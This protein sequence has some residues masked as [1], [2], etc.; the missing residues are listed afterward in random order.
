M[1]P[2]ANW[3][4]ISEAQVNPQSAAEADPQS[5]EAQGKD[6]G[7]VSKNSKNKGLLETAKET[8]QSAKQK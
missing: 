5:P 2:D 3:E 7:A 1:Y 6:D 8:G 4:K